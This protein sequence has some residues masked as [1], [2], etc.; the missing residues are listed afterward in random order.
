MYHDLKVYGL[1]IASLGPKCTL[2]WRKAKRE[3]GIVSSAL[4]SH[5]LHIRGRTS[6]SDVFHQI[7]AQREYRC[8]DHLENVRTIV[9]AGANVGYSSAYFLTKFPESR[10][11]AL[12]PDPDNYEVAKRNLAPWGGRVTLLQAALWSAPGTVSLCDGTEGWGRQVSEGGGVEAV[13]IPSLIERY[14]LG[15]IDIL[16]VDIE[17]AE[18]EVF[19]NAGW[20]SCVRNM[21]IELHGPDESRVFHNAIRHRGYRLST[22]GELTVCL[23]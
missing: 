5:P 10:V 11:I 15:A 8:I 19:R 2:D 18:R 1:L 6:D 7:F 9:D 21:V 22:S 14:D 4:S 17:G 23:L 12:E 13:D 16:K 3:G 20:L